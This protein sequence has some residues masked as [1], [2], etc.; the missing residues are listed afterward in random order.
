M[1]DSSVSRDLG[2]RLSHGEDP[3]TG[4]MVPLADVPGGLACGLICAACRR[5]LIA[6]KGQIKTHCFRHETDDAVC[7]NAFET[8]LHKLAKQIIADAGAV[9][10]PPLEVRFG[11]TFRILQRAQLVLFDSVILE[12]ARGSIRPDVI[13]SRGSGEVAIEVQ[14]THGCDDDKLA[15]LKALALPT[16]EIGIADYRQDEHRGLEDYV[17]HDAPRWWLFHPDVAAETARLR[18]EADLGRIRP[19]ARDADDEHRQRLRQE[20]AVRQK[21]ILEEKARAKARQDQAVEAAGMQE[22]YPAL[23]PGASVGVRRNKPPPNNNPG[24]GRA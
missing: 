13:G 10:L 15:A 21:L 19:A 9:T 16:I 4:R 5:R 6:E 11:T 1:T 12:A 3:N 14:V 2:C 17:L 7:V 8:M 24:E 23:R 18:A 20:E 22:R